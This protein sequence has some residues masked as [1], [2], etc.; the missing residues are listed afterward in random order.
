MLLS[1]ALKSQQDFIL[2]Q[3]GKCLYRLKE[4]AVADIRFLKML[5][6]Q[7][8]KLHFTKRQSL[9]TTASINE[10]ATRSNAQTSLYKET[11]SIDHSIDKWANLPI[12]KECYFKVI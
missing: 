12:H 11:K 9:S 4:L 2:R 7:A 10:N 1:V 3:S 8:L 6:A 5:H